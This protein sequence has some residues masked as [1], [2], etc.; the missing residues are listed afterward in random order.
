MLNNTTGGSNVVVGL[1][2]LQHNTTGSSNTA[3][4]YNAGSHITGGAT[5]NTTAS[6][7]I[8]IGRDT[9]ANVDGG[10][11]EIVIGNTVTGNGSNTVTIGNSSIT[12]NYFKGSINADSLVKSGGTSSQFLKADGTVD[13]NTYALDSAVVHNTGNETIGGTKTFSDATKN[14]GGIFLQNASSNSLA[15]YMN[16][17][18]LTNG[19]K[20]TSGGGVSNSFTLPSATGYTFTFPNATGTLALTSDIP[21]LTSNCGIPKEPSIFNELTT[22]LVPTKT[23]VR[24]LTLVSPVI[25]I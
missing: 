24:L 3:L 5:P 19:V 8:Y 11:N 21:S 1:D 12:A 2:A 4:G 18:G 9:K 7:S 15:G 10:T 22:P 17:G 13:S 16:I 23:P 6:N 14:N 20:F 25:C